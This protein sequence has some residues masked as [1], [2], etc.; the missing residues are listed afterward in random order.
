MKR[1]ADADRRR[2]A[3]SPEQP[4]G[5]S[6]SVESI[7]LDRLALRSAGAGMTQRRIGSCGRGIHANRAGDGPVAEAPVLALAALRG[8][9][10]G[11]LGEPS[12]ASPAA[13]AA[14]GAAAR[15][16]PRAPL[17]PWL[18]RSVE[19]IESHLDPRVRM[20]RDDW[21]GPGG[22]RADARDVDQAGFGDRLMVWHPSLSSH[23]RNR[24]CQT[25]TRHGISRQL[26][27]R[28]LRYLRVGGAAREDRALSRRATVR[29]LQPVA[30]GSVQPRRPSHRQGP[31]GRWSTIRDPE[32]LDERYQRYGL[33]RQ[34]TRFLHSRRA[35]LT[36]QS[37]LPAAPGPRVRHT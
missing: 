27:T 20:A 2:V 28:A 12:T 36:R 19:A 14:A 7:D 15:P 5:A 16:L 23:A 22:P 37:P 6:G 31:I 21:S 4:S 32:P 17:P 30:G 13:W 18:G 10:L 33:A 11:R 34:R 35:A 8:K 26:R 3:Y 25:L 1:V 24:H 29:G 9:A